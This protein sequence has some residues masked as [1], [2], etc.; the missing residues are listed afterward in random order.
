MLLS[1][2]RGET[3]VY[4]LSSRASAVYEQVGA[5]RQELQ[6]GRVILTGF[7][8]VWLCKEGLFL[9]ADGGTNIRHGVR[10]KCN[11]MEV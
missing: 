2:Q 11:V 4:L 5:G 6:E 3:T 8:S 9:H 1:V 10:Y 7:A